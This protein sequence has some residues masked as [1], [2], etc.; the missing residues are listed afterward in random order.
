MPR[1]CKSKEVDSQWE[2]QKTTEQ[3]NKDEAYRDNGAFFLL[4]KK[5]Y[6]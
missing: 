3:K 4:Q 6:V 2:I 1:K 5:L